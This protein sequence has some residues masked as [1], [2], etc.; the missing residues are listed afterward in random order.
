[1]AE[2]SWALRAQPLVSALKALARG[3]WEMPTVPAGQGG[4]PLAAPTRPD[5]GAKWTGR[6]VSWATA[7]EAKGE[8]IMVW[9]TCVLVLVPG[10]RAAATAP[11]GCKSVTGR[12]WGRALW[13]RLG[14]PWVISAEAWVV[15]T[16]GP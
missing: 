6:L 13:G 10:G 12:P 8:S 15:L 4:V 16:V 5:D 2:E 9:E 3:V 1:V 11:D 7:V 14:K